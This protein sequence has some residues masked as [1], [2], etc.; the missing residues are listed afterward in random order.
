MM[1]HPGDP[2]TQEVRR[3]ALIA[4]EIA[5]AKRAG[6]DRALRYFVRSALSHGLTVDEV[7]RAGALPPADVV[8]LADPMAA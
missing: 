2:W 8:A 5:A 1:H 4:V 6:C 7:A 3:A